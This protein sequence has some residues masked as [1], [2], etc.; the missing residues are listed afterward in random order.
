MDGAFGPLLPRR[1]CGPCTA[2]CTVPAIAELDKPAD[3]RCGHCTSDGCGI[4]A[5][6][7][8]P[9]R[10]FFCGWRRLPW[11]PQDLRPDRSG[12]IVML[13]LA[14][15]A[16]NPFDR[17]CIVARWVD[18]DPAADRALA[19]RLIEMFRRRRIPAFFSAPGTLSKALVHPKPDIYRHVLDGTSPGG[20]A[21]AEV[22][23]WR[24]ALV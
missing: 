15:D 14:P 4:Y 11:L 23:R 17:Q 6:R 20:A 2:C 13:E 7:P 5:A 8:E 19:A 21:A 9:C 1:E 10:T 24:A 12:V 22:E 3:T 16:P 18:R